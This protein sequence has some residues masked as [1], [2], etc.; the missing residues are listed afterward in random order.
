MSD[1]SARR[2]EYPAWAPRF[3]HGMRLGDW[4]RLLAQHRFRVDPSRWGLATTI[5]ALTVF[6]SA[7][8]RA[9]DWRY[10]RRVA[11]TPLVDD[12]VF[13]VGHW[14]SGTTY[15]HELLTCD[16][17][18]ATPT[19]YQC[20]AANHFLLTES[21][22]PRLVWFLVPRR[23]PMDNV[24]VGWQAPQE[25]EF[26][27]C[28]LGVP[29]PYLRIAFPN[30]ADD[31]L[32][33]LDLQDVDAATLAAWQAALRWFLQSMTYATGRQL[34]LKSPTHTGRIGLL[35]QMFPRAKFLHIVRNPLT[36][37]ASTMKLWHV[38]D[39][40]QALQR[41]HNRKLETYV[42]EA[43]CRMYRAFEHDRQQLDPSRI[44]DL[45]YEDLV[46]NPVVELEQAYARLQLGDFAP[47]RERVATYTSS[48]HAYQTNRYELDESLRR[49]V[50]Q[51]WGFYADRYGY[52]DQPV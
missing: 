14:R 3:W 19:T 29:S 6:N 32:R 38:L 17:R 44:Y 22:L 1:P 36:L 46:G 43:F 23:R 18:Y 21:W 27:L 49:R 2:G 41:P 25:D 51:V 11:A 10:R 33:Y 5:T 47:I 37:Y 12:P 8:R 48:K 39:Y 20:F 31:Y 13:I 52:C 7:M 35:A 42:L 45:R 9:S 28:S 15:L 30:D 26:A 16:D 50:L 4:L 24:Q 34:V 40:A